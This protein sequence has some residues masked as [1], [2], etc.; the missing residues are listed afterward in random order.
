MRL[1]TFLKYGARPSSVASSIEV[2][3]IR[4]TGGACA[5]AQL[6]LGSVNAKKG[7]QSKRR[8]EGWPP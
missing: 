6:R 7:A 1:T 4:G 5:L 2:D 3:K 8:I